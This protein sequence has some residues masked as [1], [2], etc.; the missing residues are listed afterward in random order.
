[1]ADVIAPGAARSD[2]SHP[3]SVLAEV[4][5]EKFNSNHTLPPE[6]PADLLPRGQRNR[7]LRARLFPSQ[8]ATRRASVLLN[9]KHPRAMRP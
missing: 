9:R 5:R 1:M 8:I 7:L 4:R 6:R 2:I 3:W